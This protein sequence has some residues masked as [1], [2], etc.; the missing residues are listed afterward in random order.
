LEEI[1]HELGALSNLKILNVSGNKLKLIP[2]DI[3]AIEGIEKI[4]IS[5]NP[6]I[7]EIDK[8]AKGGMN[9]LREYLKS[10]DYDALYYT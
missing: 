5:V 1:P 6:I 2:P 10:D 4:D 3:A 9:K 7:P 8:A